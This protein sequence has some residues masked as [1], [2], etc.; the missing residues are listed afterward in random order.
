MNKNEILE[1]KLM[2]AQKLKGP[3]I[4]LIKSLKIKVFVR[5]KRD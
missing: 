5:R 2:E 1:K 3:V 4:F